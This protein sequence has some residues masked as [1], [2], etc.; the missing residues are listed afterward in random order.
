MEDRIAPRRTTTTT[1]LLGGCRARYSHFP[2]GFSFGEDDALA[3][4]TG[5][6]VKISRRVIVFDASGR[7][8]PKR[9]RS[10]YE[11]CRDLE[12]RDDIH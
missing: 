10:R 11:P 8:G 2:C 1:A 7:P 4:T 5:V 12:R 6:D 3:T 9:T